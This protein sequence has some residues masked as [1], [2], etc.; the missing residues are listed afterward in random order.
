MGLSWLKLNELRVLLLLLYACRLDG[1]IIDIQLNGIRSISSIIMARKRNLLI[2][3]LIE[4]FNHH[5]RYIY[6]MSIYKS[7]NITEER[8]MVINRFFSL[9]DQSIRSMMVLNHTYFYWLNIEQQQCWICSRQW[10]LCYFVLFR[11]RNEK[12]C[13]WKWLNNL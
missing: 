8:L 12:N 4:C 7:S 5:H 6:S 13:W 11:D 2:F 3:C 10:W 9:I 1:L